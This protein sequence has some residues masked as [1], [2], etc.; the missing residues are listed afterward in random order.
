MACIINIAPSLGDLHCC[1][2]QHTS[3]PIRIWNLF[4]VSIHPRILQYTPYHFSIAKILCHSWSHSS[5]GLSKFLHWNISLFLGHPYFHFSTILRKCCH[6]K[7]WRF[8]FHGAHH[9]YTPHSR[10]RRWFPWMFLVHSVI[11]LW[12]RLRR[13]HHQAIYKLLICRL[14]S[15][16]FLNSPSHI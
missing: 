10:C 6:P 16:P 5:I 15:P 13:V 14:F 11:L 3:C 8:L 1:K 2:E 9:L 7:T 4:R 12:T